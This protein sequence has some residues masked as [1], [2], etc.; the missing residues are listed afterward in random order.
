MKTPPKMPRQKRIVQG[1][2]GNQAREEA[3]GAERKRRHGHEKHAQ[4]VRR[5][6]IP[7]RGLFGVSRGYLVGSPPWRI[8]QNG[9]LFPR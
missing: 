1:V 2:H 6:E 9:P 5:G 7:R 4:P 3:G 8:G